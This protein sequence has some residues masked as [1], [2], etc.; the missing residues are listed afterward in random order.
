VTVIDNSTQR[1]NSQSGRTKH[2]KCSTV[3]TNSLHCW[4][5]AELRGLEL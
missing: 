3:W 5:S 1:G 2:G 4:R